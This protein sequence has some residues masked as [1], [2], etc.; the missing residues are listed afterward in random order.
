M[1]TVEISRPKSAVIRPLSRDFPEIETITESPKTANAKN[2]AGPNFKA[3]FEINGERN[4][5]HK[6]PII[7]PQNEENRATASARPASPLF[8]IGYPSRIVAAAAGV[9]GV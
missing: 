3:I 6:A 9:P 5:I 4:V 2:S 7:P 8:A 1:P